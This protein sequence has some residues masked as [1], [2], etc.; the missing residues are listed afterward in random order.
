MAFIVR[1]GLPVA[2]LVAALLNVAPVSAATAATGPADLPVRWSA[3][4]RAA[5][6]Q[7]NSHWAAATAVSS[8]V[9]PA[10]PPPAQPPP[11]QP[12]AA[13][14]LNAKDYGA[15][16]DGVADDAKALE[17]AIAAATSTGQTLV[18]FLLHLLHCIAAAAFRKFARR[19]TRTDHPLHDAIAQVLP[20][21]TY[22]VNASVNVPWNSGPKATAHPLRLVGEGMYLSRIIAGKMMNAVLNISALSGP[23]EGAAAG[24][25]VLKTPRAKNEAAVEQRQLCHFSCISV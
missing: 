20:A 8:V 5:A 12:A 21:G 1:R 11:A 7:S 25:R 10:Q 14:G 16:G 17:R 23:T 22:R 13:W 19:V 24:F 18:R 3:L 9:P 15:V 2:L 6:V 4:P